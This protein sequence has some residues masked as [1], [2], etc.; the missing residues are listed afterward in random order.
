[1]MDKFFINGLLKAEVE[2]LACD[3]HNEHRFLVSDLVFF[4]MLYFFYSLFQQ[5]ELTKWCKLCIKEAINFPVLG[6]SV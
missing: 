4:K 5:V 6:F 3:P 1:M 2:S